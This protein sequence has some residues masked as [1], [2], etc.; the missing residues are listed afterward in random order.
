MQM[1]YKLI[2]CV[3]ILTFLVGGTEVHG[4]SVGSFAGRI[5]DLSGAGALYFNA[6]A[7]TVVNPSFYSLTAALFGGPALTDLMR[8]PMPPGGNA[9]KVPPNKALGEHW[10]SGQSVDFDIAPFA[11]R[12]CVEDRHVSQ[13]AFDYG[14][15]DRAGTEADRAADGKYIYGLQWAEERDIKEVRLRFAPGSLPVNATVEYWYHNWPFPPPQMPTI[16]DPSDDPWQGEWLKAASNVSC[17][18][19]ECR[20]TFLPLQDSE[21]PRANSLPGVDYRRT[22][23]LRL[24]FA[25]A[26]VLE[27]V[28]VYSGS[29]LKP[30]KV[31]IEL[32]AGE[33]ERYEWKGGVTVYNGQ[34]NGVELWKGSARDTADEMH[35]RV[36]TEGSPKGLLVDLGAAESSLPGSE[37]I[38]I[39][40]LETAERTFSFAVPD[41]KE[42]PIYVP[43]FHAYVSLAT[44][45]RVFAPS[46]VKRGSKIRE[47]IPY[48]P[49][50][51]YER[52]ARDI[53][54]LNPAEATGLG[55][56][57]FLPLAAEASW[58]KFAV[59]W[60]GNIFI[61][62]GGIRANF[63]G[64]VERMEWDG[65]RISWRIGTGATPSYRPL[66]RDSE[67][68]EL[69][70]CLPV[71]IARWSMD[72]I[73]Y[74]EESFA[75]LLSGPLSPDDPGRSEE[76]P[77]VLM[78]KLEVHNPGSHPVT[79]HVWLATDPA[80][81]VGY[82]NGELVS[83][84]GTLVRAHLKVPESARSSLSVVPFGGR[85]LK[86]IHLDVPLAAKDGRSVFVSIPFVPRLS[87][88]E[89]ARLAA[90]DYGTERI[91]VVNY[92]REILA[93]TASFD[94]PDG[95]VMKLLKAVP[96]HVLGT[97]TKHP[98]SGLY[99]VPP[100][101]MYT[102]MAST[103]GVGQTLML[104]AL[105]HSHRASECFETW[106]RL[107]GKLPAPGTFSNHRGFYNVSS[108]NAYSLNAGTVLGALV[109]HYFFT[110]DRDWLR[111]V[112]SS[113]MLAADW[114]IEQR[115]LTQVLDAGDKIPEYGL[116][117]AGKMEDPNDWGHWV[118]VNAEAVAGITRLGQALSDIGAPEAAH[119]VEQAAAYRQDLREAVIRATRSAAVVRLR[120]NTYVPYVPTRVY[121]RIREFGPI[122]VGYYSRYQRKVLPLY[123]LSATREVYSGPIVLLLRDVFHSD[124]PVTDWILDDWE[125]NATMS[126]TLG[127]NVHGW[128]DEKYWFSRGGMVFEP[129]RNPAVVYLRRNEVPAAIRSTYNS[130]VSIYYPELN[131]IAEEYHEWGHTWAS[132]CFK[133]FDEARLAK[134]FREML[135]REDGETLSLANGV[136]RRWL[137]PG[138]KIELRDVP[139]YFGPIS[140][141]MKASESG[142]EAQ[143]ELPTRDN[144]RTA[145]LVV[146]APEGK[147]IRAV[148]VNGRP[149]KDFDAAAEWVRLPL[150]VHPLRVS[151][152][153]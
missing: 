47:R 6:A 58:Q 148:E 52:A 50:Q 44:D 133:T 127:L 61:T 9:S 17:G 101:T 41:L 5:I 78:V 29:V 54:A 26:P 153:F 2:I 31:R 71:A 42:G 107:Q 23:K 1:R 35:F 53:P 85:A 40:T 98:K 3:S 147:M 38:T 140:Y 66:W 12:C 152:H 81:E 55:E 24:L 37:D 151:V 64:E 119:Y 128:V 149:W 87:A 7:G 132:Y 43:V 142:I 21:N 27:G 70:D 94:V 104:D 139:T 80:E 83:Q 134:W 13:L 102:E 79:A 25:S 49:E 121:Q 126:S 125:D 106:I 120:D 16:E 86:G 63:F 11:R 45:E 72:G 100:G 118:A 74:S 18:G 146:R 150:T 141:R 113:M 111:R 143:V 137:A 144:F 130:F 84:G 8:N 46:V 60:G 109:E 30:V 14:E 33:R 91:R 123:R 90:L 92:W 96:P 65:D 56:R 62:K 68:S 135:L 138:K 10:A 59:E 129:T 112:A 97:V 99:F 77:A 73:A 145:R 108:V 131:C 36:V 95:K 19:S 105:G 48:Q 76:T 4:Q 103:E 57:V 114:M 67:L 51:S 110:R 15:A 88:T 39:V 136:P 69:E 124:E 93:R 116:L 82:E 20:Y 117:P 22:L 32:G 75:T 34:L 28:K 122:R 115:E 89:R